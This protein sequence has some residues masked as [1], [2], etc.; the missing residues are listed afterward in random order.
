V[1]EGVERGGS[2]LPGPP[3]PPPPP[4]AGEAPEA[5]RRRLYGFLAR[6]GFEAEVV[7]QVVE[8]ALGDG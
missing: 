5:A 2:H 3:P 7:R 4:R 8:E 6:R 1:L